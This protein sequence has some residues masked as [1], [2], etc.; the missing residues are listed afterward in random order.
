MKKNQMAARP[1]ARQPGCDQLGRD[2]FSGLALPDGWAR[3]SLE[4]ELAGGES[5]NFDILVL[6]TFSSDS[7][8]VHLVTKGAFAL[9]LAHLQPEG[10]LAVH[11][12]N[13]HLDLQPV[14]WQLADY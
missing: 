13:Q 11:I 9:Y 6:D 8:P 5:Q 1:H 4:N 2:P 10:I 12:T 14:I 7:I 3:L